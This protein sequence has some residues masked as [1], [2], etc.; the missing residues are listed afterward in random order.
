MAFVIC[1]IYVCTWQISAR[2]ARFMLLTTELFTSARK[3]FNGCYSRPAFCSRTY[4]RGAPAILMK[5]F[6]REHYSC[7]GNSNV[8]WVESVGKINFI[9]LFRNHEWQWQG[10]SDAWQTGSRT[11]NL[12]SNFIDNSTKIT[13]FLFKFSHRIRKSLQT[14]YTQSGFPRQQLVYDCFPSNLSA[15]EKITSKLITLAFQFVIELSLFCQ[16]MTTRRQGQGACDRQTH[17]RRR[18]HTV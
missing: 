2:G 12:L 10:F 6:H 17:T 5:D 4:L 16:K 9:Q 7:G 8:V 1:F 3:F 15:T 14:S 13:L 11:T 18:Y